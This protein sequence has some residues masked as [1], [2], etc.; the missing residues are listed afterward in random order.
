M[1][2]LLDDT[3]DPAAGCIPFVGIPG[4]ADALIV[5]ERVA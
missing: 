2:E 5:V 3:D 4:D 1:A